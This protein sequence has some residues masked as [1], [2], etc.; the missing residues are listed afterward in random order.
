MTL[1]KRK[2]S[3]SIMQSI[4]RLTLIAQ[5]I[6]NRKKVLVLISILILTPCLVIPAKA[7]TFA[8]WFKQKSTQKKYLLQQIAAFEVYVSY[9]RQGNDIAR[10]GLHSI[11]SSIGMEYGLHAG[12]YRN[13]KQI[14]S[15]VS[16]NRQ[17]YDI[18]RWQQDILRRIKKLDQLA[19][20]SI[21]EK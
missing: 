5:R 3:K 18:L 6:R 13:L 2:Q 17:V 1:K 20:L 7:Q 8:E 9:I 12:Y 21:S 14:N 10:Y 19:Y 16:N 15:V 4:K 11:I